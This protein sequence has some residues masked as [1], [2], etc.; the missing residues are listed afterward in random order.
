MNMKL[1]LTAL[2]LCVLHMSAVEEVCTL[3]RRDLVV[4]TM[5]RMWGK[6][7]SGWTINKSL[8]QYRKSPAIIP[9]IP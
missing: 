4:V 7:V 3:H 5:S 8:P 9:N 6:V 1:F 2:T